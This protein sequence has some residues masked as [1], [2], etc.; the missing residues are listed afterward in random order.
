MTRAPAAPGAATLSPAADDPPPRRRAHGPA[1]CRA[2]S[3]SSLRRRSPTFS[4]ESDRIGFDLRAGYLPAAEAVRDGDSPYADPDDPALDLRRA[5]VYPPQLAIG[6]VPL[7]WLPTDLAA[8]LV[9]LAAVAALLGAVALVG[10]RDV[11]CYAAVLLWAPTWNALDTLNVSAALALGVALVWRFRSTLWP[12]AATLGAMVSVKLFLWPLLV[13]VALVRTATCGGSSRRRSDSCSRSARGRR[14]GSQV[15][16]TYPELLSKV[17]DQ[18]NYSIVA[19][20]EET[21]LGPVGAVLALLVGGALLVAAVWSWRRGQEIGSFTL[22]VAACLAL[23]PVVWLHYLTLLIAPLGL[24]RPRFSAL[25]LL[26]IVLWVSPRDENGDGLHPFVPMVVVVALIV[27]LVARPR[28]EPALEGCLVIA[29]PR[30][31]EPMRQPLGRARLVQLAS[32][33]LFGAL[34]A[35]VVLLLFVSA[36]EDDAVAFDFRVFYGAAEAVLDGE[37]PYQDPE[38][39]NA[40]VARGYVYPPITALAVIPLTVLPVEVAGLLVMALLVGAALAIPY[41]LGVRDWRCYGLLLLWPPVISAVQTGT[42]TLAPGARRGA[43]VALPRPNCRSQRDRG[44]RD[45]VAEAHPVAAARLAG[46]DPTSRVRRSPPW[47]SACAARARV[48][49]RDRLHG[50]PGVP[51]RAPA[52]AGRRRARLVHALRRRARRR[53]VVDRGAR[54]LARCRDRG[55]R[56][57]RRRRAPRR[58]AASLRARGRG[59]APPLADRVAALLRAARGRRRARATQAVARVVRAACAG[60][61]AGQ[62]AADAVRD[63]RDARDRG[64]DRRSRRCGR[65]ARPRQPAA[66]WRGGRDELRRFRARAPRRASSRPFATVRGRSSSGARWPSGRSSSSGSCATAS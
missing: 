52:A 16:V 41:V 28:S 63:V 12:L 48:V 20:A 55:A 30:S 44:R 46:R 40:V 22:A 53:R 34:P 11:R 59:R 57:G 5:Y 42:V 26:P 3:R 13:W 32:W 21:G 58:R 25:W 7:S 33:V 54:D 56:G 49:G 38:D 62:R 17:G 37:S 23:S 50:A 9:F 8:F 35:I 61:H 10:V 1:R 47:R 24:A 66:P 18:E 4:S 45:A 36:I 14:S 39:E 2:R 65:F 60:D 27:L 64:R 6:L 51:G 43:R 29:E 31:A 15:S 19:V